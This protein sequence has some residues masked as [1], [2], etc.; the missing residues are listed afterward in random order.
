MFARQAF[1]VASGAA[2]IAGSAVAMC[3]T[4]VTTFAS[5]LQIEDLACGRGDVAVQGKILRVH[6]EGRLESFDGRIFD[7]SYQRKKPLEFELGARKVSCRLEA[8]VGRAFIHSYML[9]VAGYFRMGRRSIWDESRRKAK[10]SG[11]GRTSLWNEGDQGPCEKRSYH[12]T[13]CHTIF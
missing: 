4:G 5:G 6:Y 8:A 11:P 1:A 10:T 3:D 12:S 13:E 2:C 9:S 7:S